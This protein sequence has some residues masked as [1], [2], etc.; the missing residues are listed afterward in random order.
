MKVSGTPLTGPLADK[1]PKIAAVV[2][3]LGLVASLVYYTQ[4]H[5]RFFYS[6]LT[7]F[8]FF[9]SIVLARLEQYWLS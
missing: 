7:A 9:L 5:H 3:G 6:Y 1:F 8:V 4:D 2:G